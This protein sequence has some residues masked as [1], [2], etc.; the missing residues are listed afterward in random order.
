VFKDGTYPF[1]DTEQP[2]ITYIADNPLL[3]I[4]ASEDPHVG[5][6]YVIG[7]RHDDTTI[8]ALTITGQADADTALGGGNSHALVRVFATDGFTLQNAVVE[9]SAGRLV[10]ICGEVTGN[11]SNVTINNNTIRNGGL[12]PSAGPDGEGIHV[13]ESVGANTCTNVTI[14]RNTI[15]NASENL[16]DIKPGGVNVEIFF[17]I[18][19]NQTQ[20]DPSVNPD[21]VIVD[22][23]GSVNIHDN[24]IRNNNMV[25]TGGTSAIRLTV[26]GG[27]FQDNVVYNNI[28]TSQCL[29]RD[30]AAGTGTPTLITENVFCSNFTNDIESIF[31]NVTN[32][33]FATGAPSPG[34]T[35]KE[36]EILALKGGT[37]GTGIT[38]GLVAHWPLDGNLLDAQG[39]N[40]LTYNGGTAPFVSGQV[41]SALQFNGDQQATPGVHSI[42]STSLFPEAGNPFSVSFWVNT[43]ATGTAISVSTTG[44]GNRDF[45]FLVNE[46]DVEIHARNSSITGNIDVSDGSWHHIVVVWDETDF[47]W[48][49]D[50]VQQS[51]NIS[52]GVTSELTDF[53]TIGARTTSLDSQYTGAIDDVRIYNIP[54]DAATILA[55]FNL[56]EDTTAP[57]DPANLAA[58]LIESTTGEFDWDVSTDTGGVVTYG[59]ERCT[60][61]ACTNFVE[62]AQTTNNSIIFTDL[63]ACTSFRVRVRA[64]DPSLNAS[65]YSN[66]IEIRT[67][68]GTDV[69]A[70][71]VPTNLVATTI[72]GSQI[73]LSWA[74]SIDDTGV[75][76]YRVFQCLGS[77]CIPS[78]E[79]ANTPSLTNSR[80]G[81]DANSAFAFC[82]SARDAAGNESSC[83]T[84]VEAGTLTSTL[85]SQTAGGTTIGGVH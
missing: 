46:S 84:I 8:D 27:I 51:P 66:I 49:V 57:T 1:F 52:V 19:E 24:I 11:C 48:H 70:P 55:L 74:A 26:N 64:L 43:N 71:T 10:N 65:G 17:N 81:L 54:I 79:V 37:S 28:Y 30:R 12:L 22:Q 44:T 6:S 59:V 82:I 41:F 13:C 16:I 18:L 40:D 5:G 61:Q 32:N 14:S 45:Q 76:S 56:P 35:A 42:G 23:S 36:N 69:T 33:T 2:N 80:T 53:I 9:D 29:I 67:Q 75:T 34:C 47:T 25:S 21:G 72:S 78:L 4:I 3:A 63:A 85:G 31:T 38:T 39:S 20:H 50:N 73:N 62:V 68:P 15:Q 58:T 77:S 7:V 83:S 60:G